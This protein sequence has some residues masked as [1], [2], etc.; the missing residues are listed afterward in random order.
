MLKNIRILSSTTIIFFVAILV[1]F[2]NYFIDY[3]NYK[4]VFYV[5]DLGNKLAVFAGGLIGFVFLVPLVIAGTIY[6]FKR[7]DFFKIFAWSIL[8][9]H[10]VLLFAIFYSNKSTYKDGIYKSY[11]DSFEVF[12]P[13]KPKVVPFYGFKSYIAE[14]K[15]AIFYV[16][17]HEVEGGVI[18]KASVDA[19][20]ES[21]IKAKFDALKKNYIG[22]KL[23]YSKRILFKGMPAVDYSF[24]CYYE[25]VPVVQRSISIVWNDKPYSL[26]VQYREENAKI[27]KPMVSAF[28]NSFRS[29][30]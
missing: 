11:A 14:G 8:V 29:F 6:L 17:I 13:A 9:I 28:F 10:L 16:H 18:T 5:S 24:S 30:Y 3:N 22:L 25:G 15:D 23:D 1:A 4:D 12:L 2:Y 27:V 19:Y 20:L 7:T 26:T 21:G